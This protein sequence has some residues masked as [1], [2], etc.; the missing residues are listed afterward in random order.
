MDLIDR[1]GPFLQEDNWESQQLAWTT[2]LWSN[3][4]P[5]QRQI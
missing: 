5:H 2:M 1:A 4:K 3:S